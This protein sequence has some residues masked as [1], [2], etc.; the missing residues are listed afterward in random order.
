MIS[1]CC[2]QLILGFTQACRIKLGFFS[3]AI[4]KVK[5][6][7]QAKVIAIHYNNKKVANGVT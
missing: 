6:S 5:L 7:F 2:K 4:K 3:H 1:L